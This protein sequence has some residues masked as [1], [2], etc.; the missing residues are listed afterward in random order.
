MRY[1]AGNRF[2]EEVLDDVAGRCEMTLRT[3]TGACG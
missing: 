1:L 3:P 2:G